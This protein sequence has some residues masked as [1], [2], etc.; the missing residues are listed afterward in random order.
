MLILYQVIKIAVNIHYDH[1]STS[2]EEGLSGTISLKQEVVSSD[3]QCEIGM[4][5]K[6]T[7]GG[8]AGLIPQILYSCKAESGRTCLL[9]I[10]IKL[11]PYEPFYPHCIDYFVT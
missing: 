6:I 10:S 2:H 3:Y 1:I 11:V 5:A 7:S 9:N 8:R 4:T